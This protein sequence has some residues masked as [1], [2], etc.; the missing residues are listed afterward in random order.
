[1]TLRKQQRILITGCKEQWFSAVS[2]FPH[3]PNSVNDPTRWE[4]ETGSDSCLPC[5][6][7]PYG[8]ARFHERGSRSVMN[9]AIHA[10]TPKQRR[11]RSVDHGVD[12]KC[13]DIATDHAQ[14]SR[15]KEASE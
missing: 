12:V 3:R 13:C 4:I 9:G 15:H 14:F 10:T 8:A 2:A 7:P 5:R 1:M 6:T 11:V